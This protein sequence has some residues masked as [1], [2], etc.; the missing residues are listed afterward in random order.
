MEHIFAILYSSSDTLVEY[1]A[2]IDH[3]KPYNVKWHCLLAKQKENL[4]EHHKNGH[5]DKSMYN[6]VILRPHS[7]H[8]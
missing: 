3:G 6:T 2:M 8:G 1:Y 7:P 4:G 5:Y